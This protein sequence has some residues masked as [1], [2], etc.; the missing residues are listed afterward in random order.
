MTT[1]EPIPSSNPRVRRYLVRDDAG[2][3]IG[4]DEET[5]P[6]TEQVNET[7]LRGRVAT[8]LTTNATY[9]GLPTPRAN[10]QVVAQVEA[11]TRQNIALTRLVAGL[12][13]TTDGT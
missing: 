11:L 1:R 9:L 6:T 8:A 2:R 13:D 4:T 5:I 7:T 12:L 10:A 3:E